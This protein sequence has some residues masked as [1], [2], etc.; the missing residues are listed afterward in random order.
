MT[1]FQEGSLVEEVYENSSQK[2]LVL[3]YIRALFSARLLHLS[4]CAFDEPVY[5]LLTKLSMR[6]LKMSLQCR[7]TLGS[8]HDS[9]RTVM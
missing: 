5:L 9:H 7:Q 4:I 8:A 1:M 6:C 3:I 2:F